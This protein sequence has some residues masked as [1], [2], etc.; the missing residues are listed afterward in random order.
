M[1]FQYDVFPVGGCA[2]CGPN[3]TCSLLVC[4]VCW[5]LGTEVEPWVR[6]RVPAPVGRCL[7]P[8]AS[9]VARQQQKTG[10]P[11][12]AQ[13]PNASR[14]YLVGGGGGC[15]GREWVSC[16]TRAFSRCSTIRHDSDSRSGSVQSGPVLCILRP[17][18]YHGVVVRAVACVVICSGV[19]GTRFVVNGGGWCVLR[20]CVLV[21]PHR[22]A[23][24][25]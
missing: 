25:R 24:R 16:F 15:G 6:L 20:H 19:C 13:T 2:A 9:V 17:G 10:M 11:A 8:Q 18:R 12:T 4:R 5:Q 7:A 21:C 23:R 3:M 1:W 14:H 22:A